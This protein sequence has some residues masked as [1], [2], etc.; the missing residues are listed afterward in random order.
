MLTGTNQYLDLEGLVMLPLFLTYLTDRNC[1]VLFFCD[2]F[3]C[4]HTHTHMSSIY[5]RTRARWFRLTC[6][7]C[8]FF[9][10]FFLSQAS[11]FAVC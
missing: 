1:S 11:L 7:F 10:I 2:S 9:F 4:T 3:V 8:V 5:R 6:N